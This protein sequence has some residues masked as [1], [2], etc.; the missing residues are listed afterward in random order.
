MAMTLRCKTSLQRICL[1]CG[2]TVGFYVWVLAATISRRCT[3]GWRHC[4]LPLGIGGLSRLCGHKKEGSFAL[5]HHR[6]QASCPALSH[7]HLTAPL[8]WSRLG[9]SREN[10]R[11]P[12]GLRQDSPHA[13]ANRSC[14]DWNVLRALRHSN[15][16]FRN[17]RG[18]D[19]DLVRPWSRFGIA[20]L[21]RSSLSSTYLLLWTGFVYG[22]C[23][24]QPHCHPPPAAGRTRSPEGAVSRSSWLGWMPLR[25]V[26]DGRMFKCSPPL[27]RAKTLKMSL[28]PFGILLLTCQTP[29]LAV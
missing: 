7:Y 3:S 6:G 19:A 10:S 5:G 16:R 24:P 15:G 17:A 26:I 12:L 11:R 4:G 28:R 22:A 23:I 8:R 25:D 18:R 2:S 9:Q 20:F 13:E 29:R 14:P 1:G 27:G 21:A